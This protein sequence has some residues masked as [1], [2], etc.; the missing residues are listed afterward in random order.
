[1]A[2]YSIE[3][4]LNLWLLLNLVSTVVC[5]T[6]VTSRVTVLRRSIGRGALA[7]GYK[8]DFRAKLTDQILY[9]HSN[10]FPAFSEL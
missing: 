9:A 6:F 10:I 2:E 3:Q 5:T 7:P 4:E 1:M 8:C